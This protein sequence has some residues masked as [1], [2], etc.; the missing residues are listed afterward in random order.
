[1]SCFLG[2]TLKYFPPK[3]ELNSKYWVHEGS[4]H[5]SLYFYT[6]LKFFLSILWVQI[7]HWDM[8]WFCFYL[9]KCYFHI[10]SSTDVYIFSHILWELHF[11]YFICKFFWSGSFRYSELEVFLAQAKVKYKT[12]T[13]PGQG[14]LLQSSFMSVNIM[15][16]FRPGGRQTNSLY[17]KKKKIAHTQCPDH[18]P[19]TQKT[20]C[21][22]QPL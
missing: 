9:Q 22:H 5:Y 3:E 1:M 17:Q 8:T 14:C 16:E 2:F 20:L 11:E 21:H 6:Y 19:L 12:C 7:N 15:D 13:I 10:W 4:L 18:T